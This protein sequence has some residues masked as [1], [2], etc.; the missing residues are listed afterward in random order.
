MATESE[1]ARISLRL[2]TT[3]LERLDALIPA[4]T[5]ASGTTATRSDVVREAMMLGLALL[6]S[7]PKKRR[8]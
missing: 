2:T 6:E 7:P 1:P 4:I 5:A 8:R 3:V